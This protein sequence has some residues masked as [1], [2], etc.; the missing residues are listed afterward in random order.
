MN[1]HYV[2]KGMLAD[3]GEADNPYQAVKSLG[4]DEGTMTKC[5]FCA[6]RIDEGLEPACVVTCP[7]EARIFGD[8]DD[9]AGRLQE[10]IK[11]RDSWH[12]LPEAN[13]DPS[14][15]YLDE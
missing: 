11:E 9:E 5:N 14:V 6:H 10:L 7:S 4:F 12:L 15:V 8:L 2:E 13:T 3:A 1:R